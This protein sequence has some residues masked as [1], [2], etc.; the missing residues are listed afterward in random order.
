MIAA[1]SSDAK[2]QLVRQL[3]MNIVTDRSDFDDH[4]LALLLGMHSILDE[5]LNSEI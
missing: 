1:I 2:R 5:I 3:A 4:S